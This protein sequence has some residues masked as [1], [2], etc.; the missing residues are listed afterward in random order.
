MV[1]PEIQTPYGYQLTLHT[2][3]L[4]DILCNLFYFIMKVKLQPTFYCGPC[5]SD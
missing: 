3:M 2:Q 1:G 5:Q 4:S